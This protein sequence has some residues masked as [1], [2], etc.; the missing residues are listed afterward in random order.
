MIK[1]A[2]RILV[3]NAAK[4]TPEGGDI[5]LRTGRNEK[6]HSFFLVQDEGIGISPDDTPHIFERFYSGRPDASESSG[7]GLYI[8]RI[9][10]E[11]LG[12]SI[13]A[14]SVKGQGSVFTV[15]IPLAGTVPSL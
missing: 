3:D 9:T 12:G 7:L 1:Q 10:V 6:G 8:A 14:E 5:L 2:A 13:H 4:Y 11:E 15:R